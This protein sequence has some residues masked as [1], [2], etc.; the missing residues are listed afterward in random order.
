[1]PVIFGSFGDI[2]TLSILIKDLVKA[3][4]DSRGSSAEY[5]AVFQELWCL[6]Q[7]LLEVERLFRSLNEAL[8]FDNLKLIAR[9]SIQQLRETIVKLQQHIE[10]Y[11]DTL[12]QGPS[13]GR[14][15]IAGFEIRWQV[16]EKEA[17]A[18]FRTEVQVHHSSVF[19]LLSIL[20]MYIVRL[21]MMS[22]RDG[23]VLRK[24]GKLARLINKAQR[25]TS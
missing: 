2:I 17:L 6:D 3:L 20:G 12:K 22:N 24:T 11:H 1:M 23:S 14:V 18:K 7:A 5:Q 21:R 13:V 9:R 10:I 15:K 19:M 4:N 25:P 8:D 16:S